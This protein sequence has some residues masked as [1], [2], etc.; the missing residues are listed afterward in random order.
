MDAPAPVS[1]DAGSTPHGE[2]SGCCSGS[3]S[4]ASSAFCLFVVGLA[5]LRR[6]R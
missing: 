6:R 4:S 2:A 5:L 3:T 1:G